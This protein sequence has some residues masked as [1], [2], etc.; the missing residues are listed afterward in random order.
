MHTLKSCT[1]AGALLL[2]AVACTD[3]AT[4]SSAAETSLV[5]A[6]F[7][8]GWMQIRAQPLQPAH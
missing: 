2:F 5:S 1:A 4:Q 8:S 7:A 6:A 3:G